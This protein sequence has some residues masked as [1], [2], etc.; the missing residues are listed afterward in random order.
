MFSV[1]WIADVMGS[2]MITRRSKMAKPGKSINGRLIGA[3]PE[4]LM[5]AGN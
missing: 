1:D 2:R 3:I 5:P 4:A